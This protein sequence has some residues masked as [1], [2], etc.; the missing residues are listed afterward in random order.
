MNPRQ[1]RLPS[2]LPALLA[3]SLALLG[4]F[5]L[6]HS[7]FELIQAAQAAAGLVKGPNVVAP[8][9]YVYY[10][11]T[12]TLAKDEVRVFA[13][14]TGMPDQ[15]LA[16]ASS[17]WLFEF[18]NG[19]KLIFDLGTGSARNLTGLMIPY[20]YL[21]KVFLSHLHTD[22]WGELGAIW[23]YL[24]AP[25]AGAVL[26]ALAYRYVRCGGEELSARGCC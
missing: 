11:G 20:E 7:G 15:R 3:L 18:G 9:R 6:G 13:C 5:A 2:R 22:H 8:D 17:C 10:P 12:E 26:G 4:G 14:G 25:I 16:S 24:T 21:D 1:R 23:I 19:E